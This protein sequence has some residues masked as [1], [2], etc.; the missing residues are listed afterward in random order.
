MYFVIVYLK[1]YLNHIINNRVKLTLP[2]TR[3]G[4]SNFGALKS[5]LQWAFGQVIVIESYMNWNILYEFKSDLKV[6]DNSITRSASIF[7]LIINL[8]SGN[9]SILLMLTW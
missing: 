2:P 7:W 1:E 5:A 8:Q 9:L 3:L 4:Y 6:Q